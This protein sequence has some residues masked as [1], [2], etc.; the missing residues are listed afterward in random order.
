MLGVNPW[1][2]RAA[3]HMLSPTYFIRQ[4]RNNALRSLSMTGAKRCL[5]M[6]ILPTQE[7]MRRNCAALKT[8]LRPGGPEDRVISKC[9]AVRLSRFRV[10]SNTLAHQE[11]S[12][13]AY[14]ALCCARRLPYELPTVPANRSAS[15]RFGWKMGASACGNYI[16]SMLM[17]CYQVARYRILAMAM[18]SPRASV[19]RF[20]PVCLCLWR[21]ELPPF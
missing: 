13:S 21:F 14:V 16:A 6:A 4:T 3:A 10:H 20:G 2:C 7:K 17:F 8:A 15:R 5:W 18:S 1:Q 12:P 11:S 9:L 19:C